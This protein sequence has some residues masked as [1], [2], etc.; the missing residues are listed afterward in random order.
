MKAVIDQYIPFLAEALQAQGVEVV[1]L[2]GGRYL[3]SAGVSIR[4]EALPKT[5]PRR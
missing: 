2:A 4:V 1:A 3:A 5:H